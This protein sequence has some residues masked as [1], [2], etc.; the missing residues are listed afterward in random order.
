MG[1]YLPELP[2]VYLK[3][4]QSRMT[5]S[6]VTFVIIFLYVSETAGLQEGTQKSNFTIDVARASQPFSGSFYPSS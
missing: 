1:T 6:D 4:V 5:G 2:A 3:I